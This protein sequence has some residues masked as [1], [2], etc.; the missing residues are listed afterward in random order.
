MLDMSMK[1]DLRAFSK[2]RQ[3]RKKCSLSSTFKQQLRRGFKVS[4]NPGSTCVH[5][6]G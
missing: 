4:R 5:L 3:R 1:R 6:S 2:L